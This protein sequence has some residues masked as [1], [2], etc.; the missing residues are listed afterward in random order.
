MAVLWKGRSRIAYLA[1][2]SGPG[3]VGL[4]LGSSCEAAAGSHFA[5]EACYNDSGILADVEV[6]VYGRVRGHCRYWWWLY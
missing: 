1:L 3:C 2:L 4:E 6:E 5:A